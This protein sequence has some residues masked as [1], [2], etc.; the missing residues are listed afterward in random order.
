M[1]A[2][3]PKLEDAENDLKQLM[4][5]VTRAMEKAR[6]SRREDSL[7]ACSGHNR[8]R[9]HLALE[10]V[11]FAA[12]GKC[13]LTSASPLLPAGEKTSSEVAFVTK[14]DIFGGPPLAQ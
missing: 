2:Q 3:A 1:N 9:S 12:L 14:P 6:A 11:L 10:R 5:D 7:Q 4:A 13:E 8:A